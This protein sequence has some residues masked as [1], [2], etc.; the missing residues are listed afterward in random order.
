MKEARLFFTSA[1]AVVA[2]I[3]A[4]M[5]FLGL[6][7]GYEITFSGTASIFSGI[8]PI[9]TDQKAYVQGRLLVRQGALMLFCGLVLGILTEVSRSLAARNDSKR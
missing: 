1:G 7:A 8:L 4:V 6:L 5:G 3:C 2:W 9:D